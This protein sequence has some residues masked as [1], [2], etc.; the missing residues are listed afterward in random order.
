[1]MDLENC[2]SLYVS[3]S[4]S[5]LTKSSVMI[6]T[7]AVVSLVITKIQQISHTFLFIVG[8]LGL[9]KYFHTIV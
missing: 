5:S 9:Y 3:T 4:F 7:I 6:A 8:V 2:F 1:M